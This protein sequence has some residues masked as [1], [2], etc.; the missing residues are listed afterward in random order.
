MDEKKKFT[1]GMVVELMSGSPK[2]TVLR[3][4]GDGLICEWYSETK[5]E[6]QW[7]EFKEVMLI[8]VGRD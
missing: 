7:H 1:P 5:A 6:F 2:M 3:Y 8:E 4:N